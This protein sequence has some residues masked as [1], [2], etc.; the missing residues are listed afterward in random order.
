MGIAKKIG[1]L[2]L[3]YFIAGLLWTIL[4][5]MNIIPISPGG[6]DGPLNILYI[7]FEPV[8]L[9]FFLIIGSLGIPIVG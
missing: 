3:V 1:I 4:R 6:L 8:S 2:I 5:F 9:I 7:V